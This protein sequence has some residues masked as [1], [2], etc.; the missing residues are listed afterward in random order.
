MKAILSTLLAIFIVGV[1]A[2]ESYSSGYN[3]NYNG[4]SGAYGTNLFA[5]SSSTYYDG[6]QQA[7][8]YLGWYVKC[9]APSDRYESSNDE[10]H[11]GSGDNN[12]YQGNN[13]CQRYLMWAAVSRICSSLMCQTVLQCDCHQLTEQR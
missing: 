10:H 2:S 11:S 7:W 13:Y 8:R 4:R 12:R 3:Y 5:E 9:G 6:Y 1:N